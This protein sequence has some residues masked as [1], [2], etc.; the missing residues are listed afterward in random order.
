MQSPQVID[1]SFEK[2]YLRQALGLSLFPSAFGEK[3]SL[4]TAFCGTVLLC[5]FDSSTA[6]FNDCFDIFEKPPSY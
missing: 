4:D 2:I 3:I 6:A 1:F 5:A